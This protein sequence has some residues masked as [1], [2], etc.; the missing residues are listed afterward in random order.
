MSTVSAGTQPARLRPEGGGLRHLRTLI[1]HLAMRELASMHRFTLLGW[2]WPLVRQLAQFA[3]LL[4]VFTAVLDL[5]IPDYP[6]FVLSGL[7]AWGW[8]ATG[9]QRASSSLIDQTHL[10]FQPRLP[11][12]A[13]PA[14]AVTVPLID[15]VIALPVMVG[16]LL[17]TSGVHWTLL[18]LPL[19]MLIQ[20]LL[21]SG[22]GWLTAALSVYLRDVA[23]IVGVVLLMIFYL[24]PVFYDHARVVGEYNWLFDLNPLTT[25]LSAY[26]DVMLEG[27]VPPVVPLLLLTAASALVAVAGLAV[28]RRLEGGFVDEL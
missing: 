9:I 15:F 8:F 2:A 19:I 6:A 17:F 5:G 10:V 18:L 25:L 1:A 4:V 24:T 12:L 27:Q 26:R 3:V 14:V 21:M 13:L 23:Q 20:L 22:I 11:T 16:V 28:F 7:L